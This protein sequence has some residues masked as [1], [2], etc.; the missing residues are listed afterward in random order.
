MHIKT[1]IVALIQ[2]WA[3]SV[4]AA[5]NKSTDIGSLLSQR[6]NN[7]SQGTII[8]FP[9]STTFDNSTT[10]WSTY[11]APRY[12]AAISPANE[13]DV[14]KTVRLASSRRIPFLATGGRHGYTTTLGDLQG[15]LAIDLSQLKSYSIDRAAGTL[16]VGGATTLGDFQDALYEAGYMIQTPSISCPGY[17]GVTV[18]SGVGRFTGL[19][20][21]VADALISARLVTAEGRIIHVSRRQNA[22]LFWGLRGAGANLGV[23]VS[24]TYQAHKLVNQGQILNADLIF[25]ANKSKEYFDVLQSFTGKNLPAK[26]AIVTLIVFDPV[27]QAAQIVAN[28]VYIGPREEGLRVMAPVLALNPPITNIQVVPWNKL[29]STAAGGADALICP[30]NVS[31]NTWWANLRSLPSSTFQAS[32]D[33]LNNF[34]KQYPEARGTT[35][36]AETF[37]NQA[38]AAVPDDD[39]AYPWRD[40][41]GHIQIGVI[42]ESGNAAGD[43]T[44]EAGNSLARR[45]RDRWAATSGYPELSVYVNY[46]RGD[47]KLRQLYG[48]RKLPRLAA[49]KKKWDPRNV[50]AYNNVLPME[51]RG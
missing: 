17:V 44:A 10:R 40:A 24:A 11:D 35:I 1:T 45:L 22:D 50:F 5:T 37:P 38:M 20:G 8:S 43:P 4:L 16:T 25:P 31:H 18:G 49:L 21:L 32:F 47:E 30:K 7:W 34:Y 12:L 42:T 2:L 36:N 26:L 27:A 46:A 39:S 28:W 3:I 48:S 51:Y 9:N 19:F 23:V 6:S 15:G 13:A 14:A 33:E 29:V 41:L